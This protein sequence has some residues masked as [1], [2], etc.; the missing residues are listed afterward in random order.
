MSNTRT[1]RA[2]F[3]CNQVNDNGYSEEA[4]LTAVMPSAENDENN[5]FNQASPNGKF[6]I[7]IDNKGAQGFFKPGLD[8]YLDVTEVPEGKATSPTMY[9]KYYGK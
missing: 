7:M 5:E 9:E 3:H 6:E 4:I 2:K 8:Y 1:V